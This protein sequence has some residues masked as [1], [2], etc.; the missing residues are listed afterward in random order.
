M[1]RAMEQGMDAPARVPEVTASA[2]PHGAGAEHDLRA[3]GRRELSPNR[4]G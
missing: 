2:G 1:T 4:S 3:G